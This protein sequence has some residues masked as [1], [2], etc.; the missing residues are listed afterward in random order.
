[1]Q[2]SLN[3]HHPVHNQ[4]ETVQNNEAHTLGGELEHLRDPI[5]G[6]TAPHGIHRSP[7]IPSS[8]RVNVLTVFHLVNV[9]VNVFAFEKESSSIRRRS[10]GAR[11]ERSGGPAQ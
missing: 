11:V 3:L 4:I 8:A 9:R 2:V 6:H 1:M 10:Q 7:T 5:R